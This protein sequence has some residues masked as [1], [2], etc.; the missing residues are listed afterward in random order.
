MAARLL[1]LLRLSLR[2]PRGKCGYGL[3]VEAFFAGCGFGIVIV[4]PWVIFLQ[5]VFLEIFLRGRVAQV[6][7]TAQLIS[8]L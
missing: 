5:I 4:L 2:S 7:A 8:C 6:S 1:R 3:N